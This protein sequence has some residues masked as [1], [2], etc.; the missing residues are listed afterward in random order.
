LAPLGAVPAARMIV[1]IVSRLTGRSE[2]ARTDR[3]VRRIS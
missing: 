3:R 1:S 2:K